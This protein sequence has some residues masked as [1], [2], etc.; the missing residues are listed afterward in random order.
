[1]VKC[2]YCGKDEYLPFR[3]KYCGGYFCSEHRLPEMH[4]CTGNYQYSR[5]TAGQPRPTY[6]GYRYARPMHPLG[7]GLFGRNELRDLGIGLGVIIL[8]LLT[9]WWR[10][11][12]RD[13]LLL[14]GA[15]L[16]YS[17]AFLLHELA[18]KFMAQYLGYWAEFKI[19]QQGLMLTLISL[20]SPLKIIAP[21]AV[22]ISN[23]ARWD[24][25]GEVAL[26]GPVTNIAMGV[27]SLAVRF[28][29]VNPTLHTLAS[30]G[31][32]INSSLALFNLIPLGIFDGAKIIKWNKGVWATAVAAAGI[33]YLL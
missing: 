23:I 1:M 18:H 26:A 4:N 32:A 13:P 20:I 6:A 3:C 21:G 8:I 30:V 7:L 27:L 29:T 16:V 19:N 11:I 15:L 22:M 24:H 9:S 17:A 10:I 2:D 33:L 12:F 28:L 31:V 14:F 5:S 25:Y